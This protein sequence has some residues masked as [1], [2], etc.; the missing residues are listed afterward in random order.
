MKRV[1]ILGSGPVG[2]VAG[3]A[4]IQRGWDI[5]Y[6]SSNINKPTD[7]SAGVLLLHSALGIP[8]LLSEARRL[9]VSAIGAPMVGIEEAYS[10]KVYGEPRHDVSLKD[11]L[12]YTQPVY[13]VGKAIDFIKDIFETHGVDFNKTEPL[14]AEQVRQIEM[15]NQ[16]RFDA[17]ISTIPFTTFSPVMDAHSRSA[18]VFRSVA[19]EDETYMLYNA[20]PSSIWYRCSAAFGKFTMEA[21][22]E[23]LLNDGRFKRVMKVVTP[24]DIN[25]FHEMARW[26][27]DLPVL[28]AGRFGAW[29]KRALLHTVHDQVGRFL[30]RAETST[31]R[32]FNYTG[33]Q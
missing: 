19:P 28:F 29:D 21:A 5:E 26:S 2:Y 24:P 6:Y 22:K 14:T 12:S 7:E 13:P 23:P 27:F 25:I 11:Y 4:A 3:W 17:M 20:H 32:C 18:W 15:R 16:G 10:L 30:E 33:I 1:V 31:G 8:A 9:N